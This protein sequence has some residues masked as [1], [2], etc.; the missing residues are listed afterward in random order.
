MQVA[1]L[2]AGVVGVTTAY[3]LTEAGYSV[4]VFDS[5][6]QVA[7]GCSF[8]NGSQLSYSYT[9]A[10]ATPAFLA[11]LPRILAGHDAGIRYRAPLSVD[12]LR[13]GSAFLAQCT[14]KKAMANTLA[15]LH[16]AQR[17][18]ELLSHLKKRLNDEF[19]YRAAGKIVLLGDNKDI[20]HAQRNCEL[21]TTHGSESNV[22]SLEE[23][24]QIEP[25]IAHMTGDYV[26]AV[27]APGDDVGDAN[28]FTR[29]LA[30]YLAKNTDC[31]FQLNTNIAKLITEKK[32]IHRVA[33]DRGE[34]RADAVVVCLGARSPSLLKSLGI[35]PKILPARGYSITAKPGPKA[36]SVSI[37]DLAGRFVI[38]RNGNDMRIAGFADFVGFATECDQHRID[39]LTELA[40]RRAPQAADYSTQPIQSWGGFRPLTPDGRPLIGATPIKGLYLNTGHGSL[41]WTLA[42]ASGEALVGS[43]A[44]AT[45]SSR[46]VG[47][48]LQAD[49]LVEVE[50]EIA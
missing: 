36:N 39:Q 8:A 41:G 14:S 31:Q 11:K 37:T 23:A 5:E 17:S 35:S 7:S 10:M 49:S 1:V 43:I 3:Y 27:H 16:M 13:W 12:M 19:S 30:H 48:Q 34:F 50:R 4:T 22:I 25:A 46:C 9:D 45:R 24:R 26:A 40:H 15:S 32:S 21:K 28:A 29:S 20:Q 18:K 33:T 47:R 6:D 38:S 44:P 2:G 42:C